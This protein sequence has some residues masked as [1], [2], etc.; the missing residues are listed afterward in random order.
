MTETKNIKKMGPFNPLLENDRV[1]VVD[2]RLNPG[3]KTAQHSHPDSVVYIVNDQNLRFIYP[4]GQK[5]E[6]ELKAGQV[7]WINAE[8]HIVENIGKAEAIDI[9]IELKK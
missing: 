9:V 7:I 8:T 3:D 6:F 4:D 1:N 2:I 5:K